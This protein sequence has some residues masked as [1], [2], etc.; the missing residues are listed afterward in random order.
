VV[1]VV[2]KKRERVLQDDNAKLLSSLLIIHIDAPAPAEGC[3][4]GTCCYCYCVCQLV[5]IVYCPLGLCK[6]WFGTSEG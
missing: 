2:I 3:P 4:F 5:E 1:C 6:Y